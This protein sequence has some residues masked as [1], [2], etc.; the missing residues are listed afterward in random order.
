ME[1]TRNKLRRKSAETGKVSALPPNAATMMEGKV[2]G[3]GRSDGLQYHWVPEIWFGNEEYDN[4]G[5]ELSR[6]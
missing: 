1:K 3:A 4:R 6:Q 2:F 5:E